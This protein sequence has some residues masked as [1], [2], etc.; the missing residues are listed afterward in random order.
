[1]NDG[2]NTKYLLCDM[3]NLILKINFNLAMRNFEKTLVYL[4]NK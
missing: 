4:I 1:M 3:K 2:K